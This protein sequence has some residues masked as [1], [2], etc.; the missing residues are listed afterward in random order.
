V[1]RWH[2][3][4]DSGFRLDREQRWWHDDEPVE[5][6]K[7]IEAFNRGLK[8]AD[9]GKYKLEIGNDWCF[10]TVEDA[11]FRVL[12][13]DVSQDD[14]PSVRLSDRTAEALDVSTVELRPDGALTARVKNGRAKARFSQDAQFA[15]GELVEST[16]RGPVLRVGQRVFP[17]PPS[18][19]I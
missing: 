9:D 6:P 13:L 10:V 5:H 12:A 18:L 8:V 4:E 16:E 14:V 15:F 19:K 2:T 7:L 3:R 11:A 1:A 17:L